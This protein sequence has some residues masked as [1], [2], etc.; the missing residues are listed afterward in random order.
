MLLPVLY[1]VS[2]THSLVARATIRKMLDQG[3]SGNGVKQVGGSGGGAVYVT[4]YTVT[5]VSPTNGEDG[6]GVSDVQ[7][8]T[9]HILP[10]Q[11]SSSV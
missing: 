1:F 2:L 4:S 11:V 8:S 5:D 6:T 7:A 3:L 9:D 10:F